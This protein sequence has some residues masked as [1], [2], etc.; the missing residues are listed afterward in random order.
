[1][2]IAR[3]QS[4]AH[5]R[6]PLLI[7]IVLIACVALIGALGWQAWR[8][9]QSNEATADAVLR[10]YATLAAEEFGRRF[11]KS[12]G[13]YG[14]YAL[15]RRCG[16][17]GVAVDLAAE[18]QYQEDGKTA[19]SMGAEAMQA[20]IR[21]DMT[22]QNAAGLSRGFFH[23]DGSRLS[24]A[25]DADTLELD[26]FVRELVKR[27]P[28]EDQNFEVATLPQSGDQVVFKHWKMDTE[29]RRIRERQR[30]NDGKRYW[31]LDADAR[32]VCGF[33]VNTA[34]FKEFVQ[35]AID[36]G[37]LLPPSLA[38]GMVAN[39]MLFIEVR[40]PQNVALFK[41]RPQFDSDVTVSRAFVGDPEGKLNGY[42]VRVALDKYAASSLIIGGLPASRVPLLLMILVLTVLLLMTAI[43]LFRREEAVIRLREDFVSQVSHELRTPLTQIRMFAETLLLKRARNEE[44]E[45]R[46]LAII[47]RESKRLSHLVENVLRVSKV[48]DAVPV[49]CVVQPIAPI[50]ED[51][52]ESVQATLDTAAISLS[53]DPGVVASVDAGALRQV[54]LNLLDNAVKYGPG[55]Q[56]V[57]VTLA[58]SDGNALIG[59]ADQGPGIPASERDKVWSTFYRLRRERKNAISGTGIGLAVVQQLVEAMGGR[60]WFGDPCEG[61]QAFVELPGEKQP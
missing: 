1:M 34:G 10:D 15:I 57:A 35:R 5:S 55:D 11:A 18:L 43:W 54:V 28:V 56:T 16:F 4:G 47:D 51:I 37:P 2:P 17:I 26:E 27:E 44:D 3:R 30:R 6:R 31:K 42:T 12:L 45:H 29:T 52:C 8:I 53:A 39:E 25:G 23:F 22:M 61:A 50:L 49:D 58:S 40:D 41:I 48:A 9:Q 24:V 7:L 20:A 38:G 59:V 60:C 32:V 46:S 14:Y 36:W 33:V 21:A 13:Q 19:G